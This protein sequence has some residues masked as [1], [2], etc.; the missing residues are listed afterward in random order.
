MW[1]YYGKVIFDENY[2]DPEVGWSNQFFI[3][4]SSGEWKY[5]AEPNFYIVEGY[6]KPFS[7][8]KPKQKLSI[9]GG[10]KIYNKMETGV[11]WTNE[12]K[13]KERFEKRQPLTQ[14]KR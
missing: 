12:D 5:R 2:A 1:D 9:I 4:K 10:L 6:W 11:L 13:F 7:P 14:E 3:M 8:P